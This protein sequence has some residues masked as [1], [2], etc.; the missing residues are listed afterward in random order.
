MNGRIKNISVPSWTED[1]LMEIPTKGLPLLN[2]EAA[3]TVTSFLA[4]EANGSP[5]LM[6]EFCKQICLMSDIRETAPGKHL[7]KNTF[8]FDYTVIFRDVANELGKNIFE[9]LAGGPRQRADRKKRKLIDGSEVDIY[10]VVIYAIAG[11]KPGVSTIEY[12]EIRGSIKKILND[13]LPQAHEVSRVLEQMAK[14]SAMD[15]SSVP[16]IDYEKNEK[17]LHITDP[18]FA[19][20]L[21]WGDHLQK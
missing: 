5:H 7:L 15:D 1:E 3:P 8:E 10:R 14:I 2:L 11:L 19:F 18:F 4:K 21:K 12:E 17:R 9:K 16:V 20:F 6:Q 13:D